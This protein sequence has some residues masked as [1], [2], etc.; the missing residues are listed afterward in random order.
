MKSSTLLP[1]ILC[2]GTGSRLWPLS[3][4]SFPKQYISLF[5]GN[6][7][8]LLQ[9]TQSRLKNINQ[10]ESPIIICN[11]EHRF[12][13]A[14]QMRAINITPKSILLEPF[15]K[16]TAPAIITAALK[17]SEEG[18][19]PNLLI[20]SAD[21]NIEDVKQFLIVIEEAKKYSEEGKIVTFGVVPTSP[22]TGYGYIQASENFERE[23]KA[24]PIK[25]FIE[26]PNL[27]YAK[28]LLKQK[29]FYW[30][31]GIFMAKSSTLINQ[32]NKYC[33]GLTS[34][35]KE[36]I[37]EKLI[38]LDFQRLKKEAFEKC[39]N[40]SIDKAIMEK[41]NIGMVIPLQAGWSD[42]GSWKTLWEVSR[43]DENGNVLSGKI[44][45]ESIKNCYIKSDKKL[46]VGIGLEDLIVVDTNDAVLIANK[47]DSQQVKNIVSYLQKLGIN[48]GK[49][50]QTMYRPW[51]SYT[52]IAR[53]DKWQL[54]TIEVKPGGKL[55]LQLHH[56][57]AEH[58]VVVKGKAEVQIDNNKKILRENQSVYIPLG[59]K[60]RLSNPGDNLLVMV[61][62]Q[63]GNY[64]GEDDI[65]RFEDIYGRD[66]L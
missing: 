37:D 21:H 42:I 12:I 60:H 15:G 11:E 58:W 40:I 63:S 30:N 38:D 25:R 4:H 44:I 53:G 32:A 47:N 39:Q 33:E 22:E 18:D 48:E 1:V 29:S 19:D 45:N 7:N 8:S 49:N 54:K 27:E 17:C 66:N 59:S 57:R 23:I 35:C 2:G 43:K 28:K 16:N 52:S 64:L 5:N 46:V 6:K 10:I 41:T 24:Y 55:S 26:K 34:F 50:H 61:E 13:V 31:S 36:S 56:H 20:L 62:V 51:G 9:E 3:R 65:V 14:E